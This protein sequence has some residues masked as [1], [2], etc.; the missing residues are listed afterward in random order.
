MIFGK[1]L[2][3]KSILNRSMLLKKLIDHTKIIK[4]VPSKILSQFR[5]T[6][7]DLLPAMA[8]DFVP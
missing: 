1:E 4:W 6:T 5:L 3:L 2:T 8:Q 7:F